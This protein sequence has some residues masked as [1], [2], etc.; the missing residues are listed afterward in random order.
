MRLTLPG[1]NN[2]PLTE[3]RRNICNRLTRERGAGC[4]STA[5]RKNGANLFGTRRHEII[6]KFCGFAY[7]D[8]DFDFAATNAF[9]LTL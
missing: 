1:V 8:F 5:R 9:T 4:P 6:R 3:A 7:F 2:Y